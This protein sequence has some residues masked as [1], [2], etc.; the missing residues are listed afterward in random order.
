MEIAVTHA[1]LHLGDRRFLGFEHQLKP[2]ELDSYKHARELILGRVKTA[3]ANRDAERHNA[4][5]GRG[6]PRQVK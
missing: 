5:G 6:R 1:G 2:G 4:K 3:A